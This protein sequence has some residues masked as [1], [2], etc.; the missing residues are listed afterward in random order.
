MFAL[1][2]KICKKRLAKY[3]LPSLNLRAAH[4]ALG[5]GSDVLVGSALHVDFVD[6]RGAHVVKTRIKDDASRF[7]GKANWAFSFIDLF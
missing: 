1:N 6:A 7:G 4:G 2:A 3:N 5:Q